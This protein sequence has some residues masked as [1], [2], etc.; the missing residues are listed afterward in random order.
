MDMKRMIIPLLAILLTMSSCGSYT[1]TG[2]YTGAQ[3]GN[4]IGSAIGGISGGWRG[5]HTGSLIGTLG[6]AAAG[7][8]IGAAIENAHDRRVDRMYGERPYNS[9][10]ERPYN[11]GINQRE[12]GYADDRITFD[13]G[14]ETPQR[15]FNVNELARKAPIEI[16]H[17]EVVDKNGDG[18]LVRGEECTVVFEIWNNTDH[19]VYDLSPIVEDLTANKHV[20]IS[21][22]LHIE[23]ILPHQGVRYTSTILADKRLK[24][25]EIV[26]QVSVAK[27]QEVIESQTQQLRMNTRKR[28]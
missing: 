14:P 22:N 5:H 3:F 6:G 19:T 13:E 9:D 16:R 2:A 12:E 17:A 28:L 11:S 21:Q 23:S 8:A 7:A 27:G 4:I 1:A 10:G 24:D 15:S 25:G 20:T 18:T 26:I